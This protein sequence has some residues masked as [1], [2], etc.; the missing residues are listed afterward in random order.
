MVVQQQRSL[1]GDYR[2]TLSVQQRRLLDQYRLVQFGSE[3]GS[4]ATR[5]WIALLPGRDNDD[6]LFLQI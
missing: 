6:Q 4:V 1:F 5:T 2:D 3:I